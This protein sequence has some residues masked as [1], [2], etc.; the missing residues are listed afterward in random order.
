MKRTPGILI[1]V[2]ALTLSSLAFAGDHGKADYKAKA[3]YHAKKKCESNTQECLDALAAK[4]RSKGWLGIETKANDSGQ[5]EVT[6]VIY[7]SPAATAGFQ[8]GDVLVALNGIALIK[9]NKA[10]LKKAK[11]AFAPGTTVE[12]TVARNYSKERIPVTLG[13]VPDTLVAQW[14]GE[15]M[16]DQHAYVRVASN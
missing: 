2:F 7:E 11:K 1:T 15:H 3:D 16:I 12:Y 10:E 14:I 5:Y 9:E 4:L 6:K 13:S 8:K